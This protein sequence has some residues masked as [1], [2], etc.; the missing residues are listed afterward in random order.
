MTVPLPPAICAISSVGVYLPEQSVTSEAIEQ[1]LGV[2]P[3]W[4]VQRSG[5]ESRHRVAP[6]QATSDLGA[7]AAQEAIERGNIDPATIDMII[8]ATCSG[9]MI[10]P[11]TA[12]WIHK[13]LGWRPIPAFDVSATCAGFLYAM[14]LASGLIGA[15]RH[16]SILIVAAESMSPFLNPTDRQCSGL[17]GDG[18][19]A[20]VV[21]RDGWIR[22]LDSELG[23]D[24][25][26]ADLIILKAGGSRAP[27]SA[28]SFADGDHYLR[29]NGR[30][31]YRQA[32]ERMT[33]CVS[34]MLEKWQLSARDI[35]WIIPH[36]ANARI[37]E[38][39]GERLGVTDARL[40]IDMKDL[41]N[42]SG[43]TIPIALERTRSKMKPGDLVL[44]TTFGAGATWGCQLYQVAPLA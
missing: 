23:A 12:C 5:I 43:A 33:S 25:G 36:Q 37:A 10:V 21:S 8:C 11:S 39:V 32:V 38:A 29:M 4:I 22:L 14:E 18:A 31:V 26:L 34:R 20:A 27:A 35:A 16:R 24:G 15:G 40:V 30:E 7:R 9:D 13:A 6:G 42:T 19:A 17:F 3:G 41:G 2:E 44:V 28:V 1:T